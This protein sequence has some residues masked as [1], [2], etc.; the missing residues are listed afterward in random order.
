MADKTLFDIR[1]IKVIRK[2]DAEKSVRLIGNGFQVTFNYPTIKSMNAEFDR[3]EKQW[4][5][6]RI[7][8]NNHAKEHEKMIKNQAKVMAKMGNSTCK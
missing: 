8:Q 6:W 7:E 4:K 5:A 2:S 3:F 1:D